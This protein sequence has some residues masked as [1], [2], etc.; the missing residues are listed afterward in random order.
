MAKRNG[1]KINVSPKF[2]PY[3]LSLRGN[4]NLGI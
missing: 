3:N 4:L 1:Q 2:L